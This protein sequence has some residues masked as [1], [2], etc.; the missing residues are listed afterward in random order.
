MLHKAVGVALALVLIL[1]FGDLRE[2]YQEVILDHGK[3]PRNYGT[4]E[5]YS[6]TAEG[7]NPMCGDQLTVYVKV[8]ED[9]K[10]ED[11]SFEAKGCAIS[12][13]SASIMSEIVK[14]KTIDEVASL[15][16]YFHKL[17][18][19]EETQ[20]TNHVEEDIE[21]LKVMSGVNQ[22]PSRIKCAT[23]SWHAVDSAISSE[24]A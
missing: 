13:A 23:M 14:G 24:N 21:K 19:G 15:F 8:D 17:C 20:Q 1:M 22:F 10:I 3:N 18:T 12:I 7:S 4:L 6:H 16:S 2:L 5:N 9:N 11:V